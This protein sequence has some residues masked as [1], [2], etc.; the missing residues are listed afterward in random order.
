[1]YFTL[2]VNRVFDSGGS[3][4]PVERLTLFVGNSTLCTVEQ[5]Q[6]TGFITVETVCVHPYSTCAS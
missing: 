3:G 5:K 4:Y 6:V 1:M 2:L